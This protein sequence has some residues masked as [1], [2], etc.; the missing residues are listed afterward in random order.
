MIV[1]ENRYLPRRGSTEVRG[2]NV[3]DSIR[4]S[5]DCIESQSRY[6]QR[7]EDS[8]GQAFHKYLLVRSV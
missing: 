4:T 7:N 3:T 5:R 2:R 1:I 6:D 8:R